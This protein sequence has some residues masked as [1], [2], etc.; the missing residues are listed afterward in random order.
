MARRGYGKAGFCKICAHPDGWRFVEGVTKGGK[1]GKGWNAAE[2]AE[3][4]ARFGLSFS[5]LTWYN[6]QKHVRGEV[7]S[8]ETASPVPTD[9]PKERVPVRKASNVEY[10]ETIRDMAL[11]RA[12]NNPDEVTIEQGL[13]ATSILEGRKSQASDSIN[14]LVQVV[15]GHAPAVAIAKPVEPALIVE[16]EAREVRQEVPA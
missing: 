9:G 14:L 5:R 11:A 8:P 3:A 2:A 10:L 6:H 4:G 1:S 7:A 15:T 16:G 13:K 12:L